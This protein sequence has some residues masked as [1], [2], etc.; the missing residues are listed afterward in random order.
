MRH[1]YLVHQVDLQREKS[2][3][4]EVSEFNTQTPSY[5]LESNLN[6]GWG[7]SCAAFYHPNSWP[8]RAELCVGVKYHLLVDLT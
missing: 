3:R 8:R 4:V 2:H 7:Y 6:V 1:F 5:K